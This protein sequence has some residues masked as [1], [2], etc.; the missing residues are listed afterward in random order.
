MRV[1]AEE[2]LSFYRT[3]TTN[4]PT[5]NMYAYTY[6]RSRIV[7]GPVIKSDHSRPTAYWAYGSVVERS[8]RFD[9][10]YN[11]GYNNRVTTTGTSF[12]RYRRQP[13]FVAVVNP[14]WVYNT[15]PAE[16]RNLSILSALTRLQSQKVE[17][18]MHLASAR[19][20]ASLLARSLRDIGQAYVWLKSGLRRDMPQFL[21]REMRAQNRGVTQFE[22]RSMQ[23]SQR[24]LIAN[25]AIMPIVQDASTLHDRL[26]SQ[27]S[28]PLTFMVKGGFKKKDYGV[29]GYEQG[30]ETLEHS[31][32]A[33][34]KFVF[35]VSNPELFALSSIGLSAKDMALLAWDAL[36]WSFVIDWFYPVARSLRALAATQGLTLDHGYTVIKCDTK[37]K[38]RYRYNWPPTQQETRIEED[39][40]YFSMF[41]E[42]HSTFP[43]PPVP[44]LK[45]PFNAWTLTTSAA[46]LTAALVNRKAN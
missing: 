46:L 26:V 10:N 3:T 19:K 1:T 41:R 28:S 17:L 23:A 18:G 45:D 32:K 20:T 27:T 21:R 12:R 31:F 9:T 34:T 33:H 5:D 36:P 6:E 8:S 13:P 38:Y 16:I 30:I 7:K 37:G 42:V 14:S 29:R 2:D 22:Y 24:W 11:A 44:S 35:R 40:S 39:N 25:F 43:A 4:P 15:Y